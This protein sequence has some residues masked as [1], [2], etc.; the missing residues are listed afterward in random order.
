MLEGKRGRAKLVTAFL[1]GQLVMLGLV[2]L[3]RAQPA[4]ADGDAVLTAQTLVLR[5]DPRGAGIQ[6][7]ATGAGGNPSVSLFDDAGV[8]RIQMSL[9]TKG[10]PTFV[11]R[12]KTGVVALG[13][14][15]EDNRAII[16][17][18]NAKGALVPVPLPKE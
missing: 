14:G 18:R 8:S 16:G 6:L 12:D 1:G 2:W 17:V 3:A 4:A 15:L 9:D 11:L 13:I 10:K 7:S 5:K